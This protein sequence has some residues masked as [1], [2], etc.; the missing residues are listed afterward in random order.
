MLFATHAA[1]MVD[2]DRINELGE[3]LG[4]VWTRESA[5]ALSN[6]SPEDRKDRKPRTRMVIPLLPAMQPKIIDVIQ[7][8]FGKQYGIDPPDWFLRNHEN[9][10]EGYDMPRDQFVQMAG[11]V[12]PLIPEIKS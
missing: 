9:V 10:V 2:R 7:K 1:R 6:P 8:G 4:I 3:L 11:L 5:N 12:T